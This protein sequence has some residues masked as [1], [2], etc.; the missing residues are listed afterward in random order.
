MEER[1][2]RIFRRKVIFTMPMRVD[3]TK[4]CPIAS[5]DGQRIGPLPEA[6]TN[7]FILL[8]FSIDEKM[9]MSE[10]ICQIDVVGSLKIS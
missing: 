3:Q 9:A 8:M 1:V 7:L 4:K 5:T 6:K 2:C 10:T